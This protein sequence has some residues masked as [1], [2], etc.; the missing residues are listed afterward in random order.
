MC[1]MGRR[2]DVLEDAVGVLR[3]A[4]IH[5]T[6]VIGDVRFEEQCQAAVQHTLK[7]FGG[8]LDI[9]VNSAAGNFLAKAEELNLKGFRAGRMNMFLVGGGANC[10][11]Q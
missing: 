10:V 9:L 4:N 3:S 1:V 6:K 2:A 7:A 8:S 5:A 11:M